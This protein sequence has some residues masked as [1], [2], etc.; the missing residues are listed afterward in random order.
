MTPN[1][2]TTGQTILLTGI[3][4][5]A[6]KGMYDLFPGTGFTVA[7]SGSGDSP[8]CHIYASNGTATQ[9]ASDISAGTFGGKSAGGSADW[10]EW[11]STGPV[12]ALYNDFTA[13]KLNCLWFVP[14]SG[15]WS[16]TLNGN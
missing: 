7:P 15:T 5:A 1:A 6:T 16:A 11:L 14:T 10:A 9:C 3:T 4:S 12:T 13:G 2:Q 8:S